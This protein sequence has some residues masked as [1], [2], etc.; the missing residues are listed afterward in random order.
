[1]KQPSG[2][3]QALSGRRR[4]GKAGSGIVQFSHT[5]LQIGGQ[6]TR[7][8]AARVVNLSLSSLLLRRAD[9]AHIHIIE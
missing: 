9:F 2:K 8:A 1:M 5:V 3:E 7:Q 4:I 6:H